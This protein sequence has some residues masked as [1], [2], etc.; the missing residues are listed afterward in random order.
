MKI[1]AEISYFLIALINVAVLL[2]YKGG[3]FEQG[4]FKLNFSLFSRMFRMPKIS[5]FV[6]SII[7]LYIVFSGLWLIYDLPNI[8][9]TASSEDILKIYSKVIKTHALKIFFGF[10]NI[11]II[12]FTQDILEEILFRG[13]LLGIKDIY[14]IKLSLVL[15][16]P[17]SFLWGISHF[18][19]NIITNEMLFFR[20]GVNPILG[21]LLGIIMIYSDSI[22]INSALHALTNI[23]YYLLILFFIS[24]NF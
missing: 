4:R 16:V 6:L 14:G 3:L 2:I 17:L 5:V 19:R 22:F 9:T 10:I 15:L 13:A 1:L 11:I 21:I 18:S 7:L 24:R 23:I 12:S 8:K 20:V